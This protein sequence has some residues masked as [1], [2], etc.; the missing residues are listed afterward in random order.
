MTD[1]QKTINHVAKLIDDELGFTNGWSISP[2]I[3]EKKCLDVA[4]RIVSYV[5][6]KQEE[7][8]IYKPKKNFFQ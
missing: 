1:K 4:K 5:S 7:K 3:Y 6:K 8:G 2:D